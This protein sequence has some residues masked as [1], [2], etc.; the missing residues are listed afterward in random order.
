MVAITDPAA[1]PARGAPPP[2]LERIRQEMRD[3]G[4]PARIADSASA[5]GI[6]RT[7]FSRLFRRHYGVPPSVYRLRC[8][9][10]KAISAALASEYTIADTAHAAGFADQSHLSRTVRSLV[11][12][13]L[14]RLRALLA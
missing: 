6:D 2:W 12:I 5:A 7:Q 13:P 9:A 1:A 3:A 10:A 14:N 11:G 8:M 4:E